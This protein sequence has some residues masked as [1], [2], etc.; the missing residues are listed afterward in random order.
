MRN[1]RCMAKKCPKGYKMTVDKKNCY[2]L[3]CDKP[4]MFNNGNECECDKGFKSI[5]ERPGIYLCQEIS[6]SNGD[7]M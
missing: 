7:W 4:N 3:D 5:E 1:G 2:K 6:C